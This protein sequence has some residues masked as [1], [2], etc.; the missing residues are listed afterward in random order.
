MLAEEIMIML[1]TGVWMVYVVAS[2]QDT[3]QI[4]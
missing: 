3:L 2:L 4:I 1:H